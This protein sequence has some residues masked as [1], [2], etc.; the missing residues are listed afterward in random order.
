MRD[1][2]KILVTG[3]S[4]FFGKNLFEQWHNRYNLAGID[5]QDCNIKDTDSLVSYV[6]GSDVVIHCA[7]RTRIE[8]S[9]IDYQDYYETNLTASHR[10]FELCQQ[11]GVK[12]F[13]YFSSSSVYGNSEHLIQI[14]SDVLKPTNPYAV[15]KAAAEQALT[16][17]AQKGSTE[18]IIVRPFTMYGKYMEVSSYS[19]VIPRFFA[20]VRENKPL[21]L[22][23][24]GEQTRD[25]VHVD[26]AVSALEIILKQ[27]KA[28]D[29]YNIGSG[30]SYS[31][32][33][34]ANLISTNQQIVPARVGHVKN[35]KADISKL[36]KLGYR[37]KHNLVQWIL[38][39]KELL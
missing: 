39:E 34:I 38:A 2:N 22:E 5:I 29:I 9:W 25:F 4:G 15:S 13:I 23:G 11:Q 26:D 18:L 30:M 12:K 7:A 32:K 8:P 19:L 6:K 17:Q 36:V 35:T 21:L 20:A 16:A 14:E 10:L 28:G 1:K 3:S 33:E 31:V 27:G 37:P 24:G